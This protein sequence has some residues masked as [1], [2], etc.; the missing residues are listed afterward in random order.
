MLRFQSK[1][2][3]VTLPLLMFAACTHKDLCFDHPEHAVRYQ[4]N[5]VIEHNLQW[6]LPHEGNT[7]WINDWDHE[8]FGRHYHELLPALPEGVR[9]AVYHQEPP[10]IVTNITNTGGIV[11]MRPGVNSL[12][13]YNNDTEYIQFDE[14][15]Q[16]A[17]AKASTR[18][19][20]RASY[21]GNPLASDFGTRAVETVAPA[22]PLFSHYIDTHVQEAV[23]A[24]QLHELT[25]HPLVFTYLIRFEFESGLQY[26]GIAR[27]ALSDMARS[28]N[29]STG[30]T[31]K[32]KATILFD[33]DIT[34]WGVEA[35]VG[36]FGIPD[37][38]NP[39]YTRGEN[40]HGLNLEVRLRNGKVFNFD[41]DVSDLVAQQPNGG[42]ITVTGL[43]ITDEDGQEGG[44]GFDVEVEGWGADTDVDI[45]IKK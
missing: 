40:E 6:E 42:V 22:D 39:N 21:R 12:I 30:R 32:E 31:S 8:Y 10:S 45:I 15:D 7:D 2:W 27:G 3:G 18:V 19:R 25:M 14:M 37:F 26:V 23:T 5:F 33:C 4:T 17:S 28:V 9:V 11:E 41:F 44:E 24:P 29:L 1:T 20:S 43:K 35:K 16:Y 36:S 34:D 13:F 38:P